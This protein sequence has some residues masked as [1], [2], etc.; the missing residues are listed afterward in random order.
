MTK[1][2]IFL[3]PN[4]GFVFLL[5]FVIFLH[6][7]VMSEVQADEIDNPNKSVLDG[8]QENEGQASDEEVIGSE[9][10]AEQANNELNSDPLNNN[11]DILPDQSL[12]DMFFQLFLAL[13][14][15]IF[16]IYTLIRFIGKRSQSYQMHRTLKNLGG[17][18]VGTNRSVQLV[19]VGNRVLVVG[20]GESI[21]L[22][23]EID[24]EEEINKIIED[25][26]MQDSEQQI[27]S[28]FKWVQ[29]KLLKQEDE[30]TYQKTN[31]KNFFEDQL[32]DVKNSQKKA[33]AAIKEKEEK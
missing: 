28:A 10:E 14:V 21:Q 22:L 32:K 11:E 8:Y 25:H 30:T 3:H 31:F 9:D 24:D 27:S 17:V 1:S 2:W 23:K 33:H 13:A 6:P 16:M 18:H 20:V 15:I 26:E 29:T 5:A 7:L 12:F 19:K 4:K